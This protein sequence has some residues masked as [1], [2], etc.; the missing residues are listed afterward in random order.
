VEHGN[1]EVPLHTVRV[2]SFYMGITEVTVRQYVDYLNAALA[3]GSIEVAGGLVR[4]RVGQE[5]L[6][7]TRAAVSY[8]PVGWSGTAFTVLD[9]RESHPVVGVRW[10]GAAAYTNWLS[11]RAGLEPCYDLTTGTC[12]LSRRGYRLPTEAEWEYAGRGGALSPYRLFP[13]GD[14]TDIR[15]ANWP[16]SGDPYE[17][18]PYPWTTPVGFYNGQLR[19]KADF[20]WPGAAES[21]QTADGANGYGLYDMA[22]NVWEWVNDWYDKDYY[23]SS[24][25]ANPP[26]P[27]SGTPM[28][29][30]G[31]Y[32]GLRGGNWYN[33]EWG[34]SRVSNRNPSYYR[35]PDDPN[36]AW[37]HIGFRVAFKGTPSG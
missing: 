7:E 22:G 14:D 4:F 13:W 36:H 37:Y 27:T 28:P 32:R 35:G 33:G 20:G 15:R 5:L 3:E 19:K 26:G 1:D 18:G 9:G 23:A 10:F 34:H 21:Y 31:R 25:Q 16:S 2:D 24:P 8:S 11:R 30:G 17:V 12:D 29:D 6:C